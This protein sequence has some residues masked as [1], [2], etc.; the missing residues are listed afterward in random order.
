MNQRTI[1]SDGLLMLAA[2][3]WG[4]A[5]VAQRLGMEFMEPWAFNACRF[6]IGAFSL[7]PLLLSQRSATPLFTRT[8][9]LGGMLLGFVLMIGA[10]L[11][12]VGLVYTTAGKAAFITGLYLVMV[13][14]F[15][16]VIGQSTSRDTWTG[17]CLALPGLALLTLGDNLT[18][19]KGDILEMVGAIFWALHLMLIGW[20]APRHNGIALAFVQFI[21]CSLLSF[22]VAGVF[23][24]FE[25]IQVKQAWGSLA[26]AGVM[27]VGVAYT[28]QI[29]AQKTAPVSH[30]SIIL[31]LETVFAV[32]AGY[33][34][35]NETLSGKALIGCALMLIG[36]IVSQLGLRRIRQMLRGQPVSS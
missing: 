33:L 26:F 34:F 20:L 29:I 8:T 1:A 30:A 11:Q 21:T 7:V 35:L 5:F 28:L 6:L 9:L 31:S 3:I 16:L 17:I 22:M 12:Q 2:L 19:N 18:L 24:S 15:G 27:S 10:G 13:P 14:L 32:I 25:L 23:E 36:M 4:S